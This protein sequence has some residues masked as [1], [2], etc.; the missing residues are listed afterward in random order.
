MSKVLR[1]VPQKELKLSI[2]FTCDRIDNVLNVRSGSSNEV[3]Q[4]FVLGVILFGH[5]LKNVE[6]NFMFFCSSKKC[7]ML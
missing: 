2:V 3:D 6:I 5:V 4:Y 1:C 7:I